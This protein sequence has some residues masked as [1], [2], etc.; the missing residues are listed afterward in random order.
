MVHP[1][2]G[3]QLQDLL[4]GIPVGRFAR[5]TDHF[6]WPHNKGTCSVKSTSKF[7][8]QHQQASWNKGLWNWLWVAPCPKKIQIFLWEALRD[9]SPLKHTYPSDVRLWILTALDASPQKL[10]Y[11]VFVTVLRRKRYGTNP[12]VSCPCPSSICHYKIG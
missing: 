7:L 8:F 12:Q 9:D 10:L 1:N 11:T 2:L 4:Q 6:L 3:L 5:L